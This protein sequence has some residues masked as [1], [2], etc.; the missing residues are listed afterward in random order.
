MNPDSRPL[1]RLRA[2]FSLPLAV[3]SVGVFAFVA[4]DTARHGVI[5]APAE[6]SRLLPH[7]D[8]A[9]PLP[10]P[11]APA[12]TVIQDALLV[13]FQ[14]HPLP[15]VTVV[16]PVPPPDPTVWEVGEIDGAH[17]WYVNVFE[18]VLAVD[19]PGPTADTR[20]S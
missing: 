7:P 18:V 9:I 11:L 20:A 19:P 3:L 15:A 5:A 2:H 14:V 8:S 16:L 12:V 1:A 10:L 13:A 17:A 6:V 4:L